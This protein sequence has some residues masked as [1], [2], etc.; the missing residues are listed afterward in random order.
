MKVQVPGTVCGTLGVDRQQC[1]AGDV[2]G[3]FKKYW[4]RIPKRR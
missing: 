2:R 3:G 4:L 1:K